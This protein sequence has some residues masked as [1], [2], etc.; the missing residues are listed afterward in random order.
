MLVDVQHRARVS[1]KFRVN[2]SESR[3]EAEESMGEHPLSAVPARPRRRGLPQSVVLLV[4]GLVCLLLAAVSGFLFLAQ[5]LD[6][7]AWP[8]PTTVPVDG[9]EHA[10]R[11]PEERD[12]MVWIY[13]A[14]NTPTCRFH[15]AQTAEPKRLVPTDGDYWRPG[16][17]A[18]G[19]RGMYTF[20]SGSGQYDQRVVVRAERIYEAAPSAGAG[21]E[22][23]P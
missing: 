1:D 4:S 23:A 21:A 16:G 12:T 15:D 17:S 22:A 3:A 19:Y 6:G 10:L 20:D 7:Y 9:H 13:E 11:L 8:E 5:S 14:I 18:G 2:L